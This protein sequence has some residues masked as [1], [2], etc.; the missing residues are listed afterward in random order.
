MRGAN[1]GFPCCLSRRRN[2]W[3][4]G[5]GPCTSCYI[6]KRGRGMHGGR[7]AGLVF[8]KVHVPIVGGEGGKAVVRGRRRHSSLARGGKK[9]KHGCCSLF[10]GWQ[11]RSSFRFIPDTPPLSHALASHLFPCFTHPKRGPQARD[12]PMS[13]R[14]KEPHRNQKRCHRTIDRSPF[15]VHRLAVY[16]W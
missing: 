4:G 10:R 11:L 13:P 6:S 16:V 14:T 3:D 15:I 7:D 1:L 12:I 9:A 2:T 8:I 5:S